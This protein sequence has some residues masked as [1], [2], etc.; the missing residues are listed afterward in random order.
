MRIFI[1]N[2]CIL[3]GM[4]LFLVGLYSMIHLMNSNE[5]ILVSLLIFVGVPVLTSWIIILER[6][7]DQIRKEQEN[8]ES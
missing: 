4:L 2:Y 3:V 8:K 7:R 5:W 1:L 6:H